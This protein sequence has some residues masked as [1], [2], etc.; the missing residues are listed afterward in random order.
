[1]RSIKQLLTF[2]EVVNRNGFARAARQLQMTPA[3]VSKQI[4]ALEED[5]G[6]Q[7]LQRSTRS[8]QLTPEGVQYWEHSKNILESIQ[9]ADAEISMSRQEPAGTLKVISGPHFGNTYV[10]PYLDE[11]LQLYPKLRLTIELTQSIPD[12]AKEKVDLVLG[13]SSSIPANCIQRRLIFARDVY[14]ASPKYLKKH[15]TPKQPSDLMHHQIIAHMMNPNPNEFTFKNEEKVYC[16]PQ[17]LFNDTRAMQASAIQGIGI[18][19]LHDYIVAEAIKKGEL[20]EI[21][22][23]YTHQK[24]TIPLYAAYLQAG[25][26]HIK[27]RR[28]LDFILEK[29][30]QNTESI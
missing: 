3:A 27:V 2:V 23:K 16:E 12:L 10:I 20:V 26:V 21:L 1:M 29:V 11:F 19:R 28:F 5:L 25:H 9:R 18:V 17:L 8:I 24:K 30:K 14:C 4:S 15:G 22:K 7:L 13:L 6:V